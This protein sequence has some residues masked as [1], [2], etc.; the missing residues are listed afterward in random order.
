MTVGDPA[1]REAYV[2]IKSSSNT[3]SKARTLGR[4]SSD[5][6][7]GP[8]SSMHGSTGTEIVLPRPLWGMV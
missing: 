8:A 3:G 4:A 1:R 2:G 5:D 6:V 7:F